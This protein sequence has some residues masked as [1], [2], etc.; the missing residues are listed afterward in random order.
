MAKP[1]HRTVSP[2]TK[3]LTWLSWVF[4]NRFERERATE[5]LATCL[6]GLTGHADDPE[7]RRKAGRALFRLAVYRSSYPSRKSIVPMPFKWVRDAVAE[8]VQVVYPNVDITNE[9]LDSK[10]WK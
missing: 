7:L 9:P 5:A 2:R 1:T 4:I 8:L 3:E 10:V 6:L